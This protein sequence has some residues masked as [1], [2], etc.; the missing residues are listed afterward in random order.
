[1]IATE[2]EVD[3]AKLGVP[4]AAHAFCPA[5]STGEVRVALCGVVRGPR[6]G[7]AR[8]LPKNPCV[9]CTDLG[10]CERCGR[11]APW[12]RGPS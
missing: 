4:P 2:T 3:R 1:M 11:V 7:P 10:R 12:K 9:V 8:N 5:C 6:V